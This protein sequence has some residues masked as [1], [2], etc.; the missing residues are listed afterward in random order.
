MKVLIILALV[1]AVLVLISLI[2]LGVQVIYVPSGLT[3]KVKVGPARVTVLPRRKKKRP[4]QERKEKEKE[5]GQPERSGG[6]V[7]GQIRRALPLIAEAAGRLR[8]KVRLDRI[9]LDVTA[10][11]PDPASAA[12]AFGGVNAAIGMI[13]PLVEQNFNVVD[14]RIRTQ[15][16]FEASHPAASL[17]AAA[18]LTI[19]QALALA[20]W[21]APKLPQITG[22]EHQ[23]KKRTDSVQ[24]EAV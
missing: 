14:R 23:K 21:L 12:L 1:A 15:V 13:W 17:D 19:G 6:D 9:Y 2:R 20:V 22:A 18:T 3:V 24:K 10:A 8:R 7:L 5:K 4:K 11:A 16:D